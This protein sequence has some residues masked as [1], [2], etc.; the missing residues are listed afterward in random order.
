MQEVV[1]H[2]NAKEQMFIKSIPNELEYRFQH[3]EEYFRINLSFSK[4]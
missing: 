2:N 3:F 1:T 4:K